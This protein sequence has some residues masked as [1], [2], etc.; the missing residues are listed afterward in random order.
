MNA[1][2]T[3]DFLHI[4]QSRGFI[5]Q[6]TD[7]QS[8]KD[9]LMKRILS[10]Y[11]GFDATADSLHVGSLTQIMLLRW[12]QKTGH[13]PIVLMG[14][15]TSLIGDPSGKDTQRKMLTQDDIGKNIDGIGK[16]FD[17]YLT[18][19]TGAT[20]ALMVNNHDWLAELNYIDLLRN[21]GTHFTINRMLTFESVKRRLERE[22]PLTFLEFNYMVLQAYDFRI[23]ARDYG[24]LLQMGGSDQWGNIISGVDL[25]RRMENIDVFGVTSPLLVTASGAK[26]GKSADGAVWLNADRFSPFEFWQ[27]W[28]NIEDA[29]I[30]RFLKL[31]TELP[32]QEIARL[33]AL[34]GAEIND[35]KI[36][37]ANQVTALCHGKQAAD[38]AAQTAKKIFT[39]GATDENMPRYD[40]GRDAIES[41][42][43]L[44]QL[45]KGAGLSPSNSEA[46]RLIKG[47]GVRVNGL[48]ILDDN[49]NVSFDFFHDGQFK[50]S[51]GKK[52]Y[53]LIILK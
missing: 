30:G 47:G 12:L 45:L 43:K 32:L 14:G 3:H 23:L 6:M 5:H 22:Q 25:T 18:F 26:M 50:L 42:L 16:I 4:L 53:I 51:C 49:A 41:G 19:G 21:V 37:L 33:D 2:T 11:I 27:Y 38:Q 29:D 10:G 44:Y 8:L 7:E 13:R 40:V 34:E 15:G 52:K 35:A 48:Q 31:F 9:A 20:D 46:R 1:S 17:K 28:R 36:I 24:C 39:E